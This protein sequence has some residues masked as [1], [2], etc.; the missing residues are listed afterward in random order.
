MEPQHSLTPI[1]A[2]QRIRTR[3]RRR[4]PE[5]SQAHLH[6]Q[7]PHRNP[8]AVQRPVQKPDPERPAKP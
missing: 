3:V 8:A 5:H 7:V 1:Q 4:L 2:R 6:R